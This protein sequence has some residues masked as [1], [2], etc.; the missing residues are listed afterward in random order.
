MMMNIL[1]GKKVNEIPDKQVC[2]LFISICEI[3]DT[4]R[5]V[6]LVRCSIL[7]SLNILREKVFMDF[8]DL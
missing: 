8:I 3:I 2:L 1:V 5:G 4:P 7:N 6:S